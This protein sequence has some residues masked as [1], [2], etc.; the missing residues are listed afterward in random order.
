MRRCYM[1]YCKASTSP[2]PM[3]ALRYFSLYL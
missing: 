2:I 3:R 1:L